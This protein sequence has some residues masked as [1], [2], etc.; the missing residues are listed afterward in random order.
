VPFEQKT[1]F[2]RVMA[3]DQVIAMIAMMAIAF[4]S[5]IHWTED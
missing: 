2:E 4:A 3:F 5:L 1:A